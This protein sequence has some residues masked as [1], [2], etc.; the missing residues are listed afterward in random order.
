MWYYYLSY[1]GLYDGHYCNSVI[2]C[3]TISILGYRLGF[4]KPRGGTPSPH[5]VVMDD[6][7]LV[8][9]PMVT[10]EFP[11]FRSHHIIIAI[12]ILIGLWM[13]YDAY[14]ILYTII[15]TDAWWSSV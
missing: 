10:W 11:I 13:T 3:P 1:P 7:D 9:K 14:Y 15:A 2:V 5:P 8:L 6:H 12:I 4:P